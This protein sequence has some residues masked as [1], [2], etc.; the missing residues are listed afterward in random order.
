MRVCH[1]LLHFPCLAVCVRACACVCVCHVLLHFPCLAV[2]ACVCVC[3]S[4]FFTFPLLSCVCA[5]VCACVSCVVTFPL[6]SCVCAC[7]SCFVTFPLLSCKPLQ[8]QLAVL[9]YAAVWLVC[10]ITRVGLNHAYIHIYGVYT[11]FK[12][13]ART[14][15]HIRCTYT[16]LANPIYYRIRFWPTLFNT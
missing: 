9:F 2:C 14:C 10:F 7:V 1:V 13:R 8:P 11:V 6:L 16:V 15:G 4:C 12:A 3:V 5:C